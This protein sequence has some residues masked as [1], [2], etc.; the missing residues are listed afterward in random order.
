[1]K[2]VVNKNILTKEDLD[3]RKSLVE[4][5]NLFMSDSLPSK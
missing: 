1:M 3:L 5:L 4:R 2:K